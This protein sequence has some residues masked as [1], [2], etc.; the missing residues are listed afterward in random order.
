VRDAFG[1]EKSLVAPGVWK[2]AKDLSQAER[3]VVRQAH[4][5]RSARFPPKDDFVP[6]KTSPL[7]RRAKHQGKIRNVL[8]QHSK[9]RFYLLGDKDERL[10]VHRSNLTP[11]KDVKISKAYTLNKIV[12]DVTG[13]AV[14]TGY[15][16]AKK[17]GKRSRVRKVLVETD[18]GWIVQSKTGKALS[19]P[20]SRELAL[21]R[22]RQIEYFKHQK[23]H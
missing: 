20:A 7:F 11:V 12:R 18:K 6:P 5:H 14:G 3:V 13:Q 16:R 19:K 8:G 4:L 23:A 21:K 22:L 10:M 1:V 15:S 2:P 9:D 17:K